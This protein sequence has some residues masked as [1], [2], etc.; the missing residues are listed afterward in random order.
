MQ[1]ARLVWC[2]LAR[3]EAKAMGKGKKDKKD[4]KKK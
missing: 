2:H 3:K 4:K 1:F